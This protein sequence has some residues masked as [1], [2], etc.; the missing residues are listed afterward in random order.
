MLNDPVAA[1]HGRSP[2]ADQLVAIGPA[3]LPAVREVLGGNWTSD[4]H[5]KDVI[6]A[7]MLIAQHIAAGA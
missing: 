5:P 1:L 7:F 4:A 6:E 3:A 2:A